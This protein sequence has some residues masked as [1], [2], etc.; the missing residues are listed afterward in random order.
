MTTTHQGHRP[1]PSTTESGYGQAM[2]TGSLAA[3]WAKDDRIR[4]MME[5]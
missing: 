4:A 5:K 3:E 1:P 2:G